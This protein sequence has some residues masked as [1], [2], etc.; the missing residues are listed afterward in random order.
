[1]DYSK[2]AIVTLDGIDC[3]SNDNTILGIRTQGGRTRDGKDGIWRRGGDTAV[4]PLLIPQRRL[5]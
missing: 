4:M 3:I 2:N 5:P 1:M